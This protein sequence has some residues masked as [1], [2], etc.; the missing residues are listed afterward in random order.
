MVQN[1]PGGGLLTVNPYAGQIANT[2]HGVNPGHAANYGDASTLPPP[3]PPPSTTLA[4]KWRGYG[5]REFVRRG[6]R[7]AAR[8]TLPGWLWE[9]NS[10]APELTDPR[11]VAQL[12]ALTHLLG[13]LVESDAP[14]REPLR[15]GALR[16]PAFDLVEPNEASLWSQRRGQEA[17]GEVGGRV[18]FGLHEINS[19]A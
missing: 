9:E 7:K 8:L 5:P 19:P 17:S 13:Q 10:T 6:I 15:S 18:S 14:H 11:T 4:Q 2:G 3:E 1:N 12:R 16:Q